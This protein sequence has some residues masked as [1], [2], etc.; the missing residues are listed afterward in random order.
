M[1]KIIPNI[2]RDGP[3]LQAMKKGH[4]VLLDE[5]NLASQQVLE[6][7]NACLDH[8][9][10]VYI[11]ELDRTFFCHHDFRVFAA[12][13]PYNQGGGRKGLPRSFLN[14]FTQVYIDALTNADL[15]FICGV[16][17]PNVNSE[18][19]SKMISF[20]ERIKKETMEMRSF[21]QFGSPWEFNLRDIL[22]WISLVDSR[23]NDSSNYLNLLYVHRMRTL[24][25]RYQV[26]RIYEEVFGLLPSHLIHPPIFRITENHVLIGSGSY[27]R[28][29]PSNLKA[30]ELLPSNLSIMESLLNCV[31]ANVMPLL[32]GPSS[33]GKTSLVRLLASICGEELLELSLN[34][35]ID[36]LDLLGGFEQ[37]DINRREED[38]IESMIKLTE[39]LSESLLTNNLR[40]EFIEINIAAENLL[41]K[42]NRTPSFFAEFFMHLKLYPSISDELTKIMKNYDRLGHMTSCGA[43][44][45][46]EWLDSI[47]VQAVEQGKWILLDNV[48]LCSSNVLDRL[49]SLLE[50]GGTLILNERGLVD[51]EIKVI[52]PH[53]NFRIFMAMNPIYGEIS[54]AMRNR[55][56]ELYVEEFELSENGSMLSNMKV[57]SSIGLPGITFAKDFKFYQENLNIPKIFLEVLYQGVDHRSASESIGISKNYIDISPFSPVITSF[58]DSVPGNLL[59][60]NS[61]VANVLF[62]GSILF[63]LA[64]GENMHF[65]T[66]ANEDN[67]KLCRIELIY[68][69][70]LLFFENSCSSDLKLRFQYLSYVMANSDVQILKTIQDFKNAYELI[71]PDSIAQCFRLKNFLLEKE[72]LDTLHSQE[73]PLLIPN[74]LIK[75]SSCFY[76][77]VLRVELIIHDMF[78]K[79]K[80]VYEN[81]NSVKIAEMNMAQLSYAFFSG[82]I[83]EAALSHT[84][85]KLF[86]GLFENC[87]NVFLDLITLLF[88]K[89]SVT[90]SIF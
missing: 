68:F 4:W 76:L 6:G 74:T 67:V 71:R 63:H 75:S 2:R 33:S 69:A 7:L 11:P 48:N 14:R 66:V 49:N 46:F 27:K 29:H 8:R 17:Y 10:S 83:R 70:L 23:K 88:S 41:C 86:Y 20:N 72:G 28:K 15:E 82:R 43:Q 19:R 40:R 16:L 25:D 55:A 22:R 37:V 30:L 32:V 36:S 90:V 39:Q 47:L 3:F 59:I 50:T 21:G 61:R 62:D 58:P 52:I 57:L 5:L 56:I 45:Q 73:L 54:R 34:P 44:G 81:T 12:Q 65:F 31:N 87:H 1:V 77:C 9:G 13:N 26:R 18:V 38:L 89:F 42:A 80:V 79:R 51:G 35:G 53:P 84:F 24:E 78:N 60:S 64:T 85:I